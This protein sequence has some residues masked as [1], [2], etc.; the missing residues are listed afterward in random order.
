MSYRI[1]GAFL[2]LASLA[3]AGLGLVCFLVPR[4]V[5]HT[6]YSSSHYLVLL[7][8]IACWSWFVSILALSGGRYCRLRAMNRE[9]GPGDERIFALAKILVGL[10]V[11]ILIVSALFA[12]EIVV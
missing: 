9:P 11:L 2:L 4:P 5:I 8:W 6:V 10:G 3:F 7:R 1:A 12:P